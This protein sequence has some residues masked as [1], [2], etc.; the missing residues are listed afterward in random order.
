[1]LG[2]DDAV[3]RGET[4]ERRHA[5]GR[6]ELAAYVADARRG[7]FASWKRPRRASMEGNLLSTTSE[8]THAQEFQPDL[9]ASAPQ[10]PTARARA[11]EK[12]TVQWSI[13]VRFWSIFGFF[14]P[15][16]CLIMSRDLST[17]MSENHVLR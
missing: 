17:K 16:Y 13:L 15:W 14:G 7:T 12:Q 1:M 3:K 9:A 5:G 11:A 8:R 4:A 10:T 6:A 2:D